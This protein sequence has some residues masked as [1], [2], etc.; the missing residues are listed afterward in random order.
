MTELLVTRTLLRSAHD[1]GLSTG[2]S[3]SKD[4]NN[5]ST[6]NTIGDNNRHKPSTFDS[7]PHQTS[8]NKLKTYMPIFILFMSKL[9]I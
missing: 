8:K 5:L 3:A 1:N 9:N 7:Q 2:V 6:F 4:H